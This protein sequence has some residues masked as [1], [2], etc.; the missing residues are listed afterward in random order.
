MAFGRRGFRC[1]ILVRAVRCV[2]R[3]RQFAAIA[4]LASASASIGAAAATPA[5]AT[6]KIATAAAMRAAIVPIFVTWM[7]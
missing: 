1:W 2:F 7:A 3:L 6:A 4:A 5:T